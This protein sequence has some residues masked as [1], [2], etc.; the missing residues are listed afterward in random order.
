MDLPVLTCCLLYHL[1]CF[2]LADNLIYEALGYGYA[3][4]ILEIDIPQQLCR[5]IIRGQFFCPHILFK[6]F[7]TI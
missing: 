3:A 4:G 1:Y 2:I 5:L 7:L 6:S